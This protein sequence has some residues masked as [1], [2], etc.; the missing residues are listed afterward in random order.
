[1]KNIPLIIARSLLQVAK[2]EEKDSLSE[3]EC[4]S[5]ENASFFRN[6]K[7]YWNFQAEEIPNERVN[8][9]NQRLL[10]RLNTLVPIQH[11]QKSFLY[12][13]SRIAALLFLIVT[14]AGLSIYIA[15]RTGL[16]YKPGR[17][18][19]ATEA[20]QRSQ[21]TLP[22]GSLVWLNSET[23]LSYY[24]QQNHRIVSL[25][26]EAYFEVTHNARRPFI[27]ETGGTQIKVLGTKFNV[28]HYPDSKITEAALLTGKITMSMQGSKEEIKLHPGQ[29][30]T[31]DAGKHVYLKKTTA[32][33]NV[34]LWRQGILV[35]DNEPFTDLIQKLERYYDVK[36]IYNKLNFENIHYTGTI[37]NLSIKKVFDF[38]N[39]TIPVKYEIENKTIRL[40]SSS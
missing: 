34:I 20:G 23:R 15:S 31:Y 16:L 9:A 13:S 5:D 3:W 28:S 33:R 25:S 10:A 14:F 40:S 24:T 27:V 39:L 29:E 32:V 7:E 12:Y 35:F 26:G 17:V 37:N 30:I 4:V 38:I 36:I 6:I 11:H 8:V 21:V 2:K 19:V 18:Q 22:D 1:M